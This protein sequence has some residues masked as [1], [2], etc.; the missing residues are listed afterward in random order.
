VPQG[1]PGRR[2]AWT[3]ASC[4]VRWT[5]SAVRTLYDIV[6]LRTRSTSTMWTLLL[7]IAAVSLL[8]WG[9]G[10]MNIMLVSV[11]ERTREREIGLR[12]ALGAI[13]PNRGAAVRMRL[14][15][16]PA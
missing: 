8:V 3:T 15:A 5:T 4:R 16:S 7:A 10:V 13:D 14:S 2:V 6:E 12:L 11:T 1:T 9:I